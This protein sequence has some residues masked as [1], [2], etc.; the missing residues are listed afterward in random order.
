[1]PQKS[2]GRTGRDHLA[3]S[4][5][6]PPEILSG[7]LQ[8]STGNEGQKLDKQML[9]TERPREHSPVWRGREHRMGSRCCFGRESFADWDE[10]FIHDDEE[11]VASQVGSLQVVQI[12]LPQARLVAHQDPRNPEI[13]PNALG[14]RLPLQPRP[15]GEPAGH[16]GR[17]RS[18]S[19]KLWRRPSYRDFQL[20][21]DSD[22]HFDT[23][24][25]TP[26]TECMP[27][28]TEGHAA[29]VGSGGSRLM[30]R[31]QPVVKNRWLNQGGI[32]NAKGLQRAGH[33]SQPPPVFCRQQIPILVYRAE[34][35]Q[36][37]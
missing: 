19:R 4:R 13:P 1:M 18:K 37:R 33:P 20:G 11:P 10:G 31:P 34:H 30:E 26:N 24:S 35:S 16:A 23:M 22:N 3:V 12:S 2:R 6:R 36:F 27:P 9:A 15:T 25:V 32:K 29:I 7:P 28:Q 8:S 14:A 21:L 5:S 17:S